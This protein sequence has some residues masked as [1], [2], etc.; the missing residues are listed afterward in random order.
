MSC[1]AVTTSSLSQ[2]SMGASRAIRSLG[3]CRLSSVPA[4]PSVSP[5]IDSCRRYA[6][7][8]A[9]DISHKMAQLSR[10]H[11]TAKLHQAKHVAPFISYSQLQA[12][13]P[14]SSCPPLS[15]APT[16]CRQDGPTIHA[17]RHSWWIWT[18][19]RGD[20]PRAVRPDSGL[21]LPSGPSRRWLTR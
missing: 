15:A 9:V 20:R 10:H 5:Q 11:T 1:R 12:E 13:T 2:R 21:R 4:Y 18:W 8:A 17:E 6:G 19:E 16:R 14:L 7:E 3:D